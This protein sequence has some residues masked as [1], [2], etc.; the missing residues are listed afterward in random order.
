LHCLYH[1]CEFSAAHY[2]RD[3]DLSAHENEKKYGPYH[4]VHGH[5]FRVTLGLKGELDPGSGMLINFY[6]IH[7]LVEE[8]IIR[9]FDIQTINDADPWFRE[10]LP[11]TENLALYFYNRLKPLIPPGITLFSVEVAE[12]SEFS[13]RFEP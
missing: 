10:H 13:S 11:S 3:A 1:S 12:N 4:R 9:P 8:Q 5:N 7:E 2:Y 6:D